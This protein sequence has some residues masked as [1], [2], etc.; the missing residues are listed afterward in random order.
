METIE[1][2]NLKVKIEKKNC[3]YTLLCFQISPREFDFS[4]LNMTFNLKD[5]TIL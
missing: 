2:L 3:I 1:L 5:S 4:C